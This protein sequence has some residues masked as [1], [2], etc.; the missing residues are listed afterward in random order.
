[1]FIQDKKDIKKSACAAVSIYS[2]DA[3]ALNSFYGGMFRWA[4]QP[5]DMA[6]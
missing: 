1:M 4:N 3:M 6:H 2:T 5:R